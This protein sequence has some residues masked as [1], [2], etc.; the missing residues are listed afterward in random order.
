MAKE[1]MFYGR[2]TEEMQKMSMDDFIKLVPSRARR[3]FTRGLTAAEKIFMRNLTKGQSDL[4]THCRDLVIVPAMLGKTIK[5]Y[6]GKE[7]MPVA[8][9]LNMLGHR[10]GEFA[11]TTK[12]VQHS[13]PGIGA[14]RSSSALS[15]R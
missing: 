3:K 6:N 8:I 9:E 11:P 12:R 13:A 14:T 10:L 15:V 1:F 7:F 4:H 5:V 2:T